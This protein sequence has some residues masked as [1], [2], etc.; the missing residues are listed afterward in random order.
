MN[1][2][3]L[4]YAAVIVAICSSLV[5]VGV[6]AWV[7]WRIYRAELP[8]RPVAGILLFVILAM[9]VAQA[10]EQTRVLVFRLS[11]DNLIE[12]ISF[13]GLY[14]STWNVVSSKLLMSMAMTAGSILQL[15][16]AY[17]HNTDDVRRFVALGWMGTFAGWAVL[18]LLLEV[19]L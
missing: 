17:H 11:Y 12:S 9:A 7:L 14:N 18:A 8:S 2:D 13:S 19:L 6:G 16:L 4:I 1:V 10:L 3:G 5:A 15:A